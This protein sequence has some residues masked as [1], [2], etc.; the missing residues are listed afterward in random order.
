VL[1]TR[2]TQEHEAW[3]VAGVPVLGTQVGCPLL[4]YCRS[5]V[6]AVEEV[7]LPNI[8]GDGCIVPLKGRSIQNE[9]TDFQVID[10]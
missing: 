10:V 6:G 7:S 9:D 5:V 4:G 2:W 1:T 3:N 8:V